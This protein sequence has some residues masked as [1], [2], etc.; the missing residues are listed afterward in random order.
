MLK[1]V[2]LVKEREKGWK[3]KVKREL[4]EKELGTGGEGEW[5]ER[6]LKRD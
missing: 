3:I 5:R 2:K 4:G 1:L 6:E